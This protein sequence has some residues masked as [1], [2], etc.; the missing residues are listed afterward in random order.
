MT[1]CHIFRFQDY[2]NIYV[3]RQK[4]L[5]I[6][7]FDFFDYTNY[8]TKINFYQLL[9]FLFQYNIRLGLCAPLSC[10][11]NELSTLIQNYMDQRYLHIQNMY[12]LDINVIKMRPLTEDLM[13][14]LEEPA[15]IALL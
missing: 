11:E 3:P 15:M 4:L 12:S 13:W 5:K 9:L 10:S 1:F 8:Y 7:Y 14:L 2:K 6:F